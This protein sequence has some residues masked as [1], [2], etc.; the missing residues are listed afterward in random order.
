MFSTLWLTRSI[1]LLFCVLFCVRFWPVVCTT[2]ISPLLGKWA[3]FHSGRDPLLLSDGCQRNM[4]FVLKTITILRRLRMIFLSASIM[5]VIF[6]PFHSVAKH[7][8]TSWSWGAF[9]D[10][11]PQI[12]SQMSHLDF[13]SHALVWVLTAPILRLEASLYWRKVQSYEE[14]ILS[15]Y[16]NTL[17]GH[18]CLKL[19]FQSYL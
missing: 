17:R 9:L 15:K 14:F 12:S 7:L 2:L 5:D 13:Q 16:S 8:L 18:F 1:V 10:P 6:Q 19:E 4:G 3:Y 11:L